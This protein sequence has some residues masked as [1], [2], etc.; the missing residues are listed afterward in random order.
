MEKNKKVE[1]KVKVPE[2]FP[3]WSVY[4]QRNHSACNLPV[5]GKMNPCENPFKFQF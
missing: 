2:A 5:F 4:G 1:V 3:L